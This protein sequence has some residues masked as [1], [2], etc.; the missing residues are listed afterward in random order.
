MATLLSM[1]ELIDQGHYARL[2]SELS[3]RKPLKDFLLQLFSVLLQLV[4]QREGEQVFPNTWRAMHSVVNRVI[5]ASVDH[6]TIPLLAY[7]LDSGCFDS[8]VGVDAYQFIFSFLKYND[9]STLF[10]MVQ[11]WSIYFDFG[12]AFLTQHSL[13]LEKCTPSQ[14]LKIIRAQGG[15]LRVRMGLQILNMWNAIGDYKI[16]FIPSMVGPFLQVTLVPEPTL[17]R[18]TL[19]IFFDMLDCENRQRG[20]FKQVNKSAVSIYIIM[21]KFLFKYTFTRLI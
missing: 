11:L 20:N 8:K 6:L 5:L 15:D 4:R 13:Q 9:R 2:W 19:P 17:R 14:K 1:L 3:E 21:D 10:C 7:F 12:V 18:A 16:N